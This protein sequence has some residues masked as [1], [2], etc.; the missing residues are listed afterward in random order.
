MELL[1]SEG[2]EMDAGE[3]MIRFI[4]GVNTGHNDKF[5]LKRKSSKRV[6]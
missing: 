4:Q 3:T 6:H 1:K 5:Y 2:K